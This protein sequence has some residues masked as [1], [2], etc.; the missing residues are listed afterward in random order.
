M[1][2]W[3]HRSCRE[4]IAMPISH[5]LIRFLL[6]S[7]M[8]SSSSLTDRIKQAVSDADRAGLIK[9]DASR[10]GVAQNLKL[11]STHYEIV[12]RAKPVRKA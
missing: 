6:S 10:D 7:D 2:F 9:S 12:R 8:P 4:Q 11:L 5:H 3:L 1:A